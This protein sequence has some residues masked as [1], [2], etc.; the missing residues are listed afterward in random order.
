MSAEVS[1]PQPRVAA[2]K[3]LQ[4]VQMSSV[5]A[6]VALGCTGCEAR[7]QLPL[8]PVAPMLDAVGDFVRRHAPC[9]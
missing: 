7:L 8:E 6:G 2:D 5:D 3:H 4:P 9:Q 1:I